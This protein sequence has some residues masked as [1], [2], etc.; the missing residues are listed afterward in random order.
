MNEILF[1]LQVISVTIFS[2]CALRMGKFAL[3]A[4]VCLMTV[5]ANLFVTKQIMLFGR[6]ATA[7]DSYAVGAMFGLNLLQEY[8][9]KPITKK[10][11]WIS[12]FMLVIYAVASQLHLAYVPSAFDSMHAHF[13]AILSTA[14]RIIIASFISFLITQ[15]LDAWLYGSF[16]KLCKNRFYLIRN[17]GSLVISQFVD[18]VLFSF[19]GLYGIVAHIGSIIAVSYSIKL[20]IILLGT[21]FLAFSKMLIK[22]PPL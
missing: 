20:M 22:K 10:T 6:F 9:G 11:I 21:P 1:C 3:V 19:L 5:L 12:F 13:T 15:H 8:F 14:P 2:L 7:S 18:T 17:Y 16:K 4:F